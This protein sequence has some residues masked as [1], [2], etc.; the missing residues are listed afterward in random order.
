MITIPLILSCTGNG[1][2]SD[3][4]DSI[5]SFMLDTLVVVDSIGVIMGDSTKIFGGITS[6][7]ALPEERLAVLDRITGKVSVFTLGGDFQYSFGGLGSGP[8]RFQGPI[9][10]GLMRDGRFLIQDRM[11]D[12]FIVFSQDGVYLHSFAVDYGYSPIAYNVLPCDDSTFVTYMFTI[13]LVDQSIVHRYDIVRCRIE[14]GETITSYF[15]NQQDIEEGPLDFLSCYKVVT[16]GNDGEV[17][18]SDYV[19]DAYE[20]QVFSAEGDS[21]QTLR[22][23][24]ST[25]PVD[26]D[27][28]GYIVPMVYLGRDIGDPRDL[29]GRYPEYRPFVGQMGVDSL[30]NLWARRGTMDEHIWD[31]FSPEGEFLGGVF[32]E[33]VPINES[34]ILHLNRYG[35]AAT[36][37]DPEDYPR[38][39]ILSYD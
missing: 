38:V 12:E 8:G 13:Q 16:T 37:F 6:V 29:P 10:M 26:E 23:D 30:G 15:S 32:L 18:I 21:I 34:V 1:T 5:D 22:K 4:P 28:V 3:D 11:G 39:Y 17:Y 36:V 9:F 2:D 33:G 14:D 20:I 24:A 35:A 31:V 19:S 27:D 7:V 25:V